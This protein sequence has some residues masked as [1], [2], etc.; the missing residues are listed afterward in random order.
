MSRY[1]TDY[2]ALKNEVRNDVG[3]RSRRKEAARWAEDG[4][5]RA[6]KIRTTRRRRMRKLQMTATGVKV[7]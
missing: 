6:S 5:R 2:M 7:G 3:S 4:D 1:S